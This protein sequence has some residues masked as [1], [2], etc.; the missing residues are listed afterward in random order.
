MHT[1]GRARSVCGATSARIL[2]PRVSRE[3]PVNSLVVGRR[4]ARTRRKT[5]N[6]ARERNDE[7][8]LT[9][10]SLTYGTYVEPRVQLAYQGV[11]GTAHRG[12]EAT[13]SRVTLS[14]TYPCLCTERF[15]TSFAND[16]G[17]RFDP[18]KLSISR[19]FSTSEAH[20]NN[21]A[22]KNTLRQPGDSHRPTGTCTV[23]PPLSQSIGTFWGTR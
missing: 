10:A 8:Q 3:C 18:I 21:E 7:G 13:P 22:N 19:A 2:Y 20:I 9:Y 4:A 17:H 12:D 23:E 5:L 15:Q 11:P 1:N 14:C 6:R 16:C